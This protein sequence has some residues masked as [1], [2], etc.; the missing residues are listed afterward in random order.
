MII[1]L[2]Y[3]GL[4]YARTG[5]ADPALA[6]FAEVVNRVK[7]RPDWFALPDFFPRRLALLL[8]RAEAYSLKG[9][10]GRAQA[11]SDDAVRFAPESADAR[12]LRARVSDKRG[13]S[14]L[15]EADR[16]AAAGLHHDPLF[17]LPEPRT[18]SSR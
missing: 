17:A 16:R 9:D 14:D 3:R 15:A 7:V 13:K 6:D 12:L 11:D 2:L 8:R 10:L 5:K 1:P 18:A 4:I